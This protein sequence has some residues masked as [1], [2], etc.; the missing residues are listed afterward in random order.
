MSNP[1]RGWFSTKPSGNLF[2]TIEDEQNRIKETA[3]H[4]TIC[5][6]C[7]RFIKIYNRPMNSSQAVSLCKA[8]RYIAP[9]EWFHVS[10]FD[11]PKGA[12]FPKL[13]FWGLIEPSAELKADGNKAGFY[14]VT[15][16]GRQFVLEGLKVPKKISTFR[17]ELLGFSEKQTDIYQ[18]LGKHFNYAELMGDHIL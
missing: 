1:N 2:P 5:K 11:Y 18:A 6:C 8:V 17:N 4:G 3:A 10:M 14:R 13:R 16:K 12:D 9:D 7:D 15:P